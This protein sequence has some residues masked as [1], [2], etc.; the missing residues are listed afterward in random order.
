MYHIYEVT[1]PAVEILQGP[2]EQEIGEAAEQCWEVRTSTVQVW[3]T[4]MLTIDM[5]LEL[6]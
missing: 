1:L 3:A 4:K 6:D 2:L 5:L